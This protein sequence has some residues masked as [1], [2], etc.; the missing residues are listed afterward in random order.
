MKAVF[1]LAL[2][3]TAITLVTPGVPLRASETDDRIESSFKKSYVYTTYLK[4]D[5]IKTDAR[6][7]VVTLT[8][9]VAEDSH[10]S[11]AQETV[12]ELP[13]VERVDNRLQV[14]SEIPAANSDAWVRARVRSMLA[15]H[16]AKS[17]SGAEVDVKDGMIILRGK[18]A[19]ESQRESTTQYAKAVEGV[20]EVRND[21]TI[22]ETLEDS[23]GT[24]VRKI[25]DASIT[26]QAKLTLQYHRS[27]CGLATK[28]ET[29][30][31][32]VRLSGK[33]R[34]SAEKDTVAMLVAGIQGVKSVVDIDDGITAYCATSVGMQRNPSERMAAG[35]P[36]TRLDY[37]VAV[38]TDP[39]SAMNAPAGMPAGLHRNK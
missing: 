38:S 20:K 36:G 32:V 16:R 6:G 34:N 17:N 39:K 37:K 5:A 8:G 31:G 19:S 13:G 12:A 10:K 15:F 24:T 33:T 25:D 1:S 23:V 11:L 21:M 14:K 26:A 7:G 30:D 4:D 29:T 35:P 3:V 9:N 28:V 18:A 27:T 2:V 22:V